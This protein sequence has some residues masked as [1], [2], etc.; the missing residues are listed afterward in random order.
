[1]DRTDRVFDAMTA[2]MRDWAA[3]ATSKADPRPPA[4]PSRWRLLLAVA[5]DMLACV[6]ELLL[7]LLAVAVLLGL[8]GLAA[9]TVHIGWEMAG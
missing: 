2:G 4:P 7:A 9:A 6:G 8:L 3:I 1:M 5:A